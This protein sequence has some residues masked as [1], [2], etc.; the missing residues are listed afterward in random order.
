MCSCCLSLCCWFL[1]LEAFLEALERRAG[2][3]FDTFMVIC[4]GK[5]CLSVVGPMSSFAFSPVGVHSQAL[6]RVCES[7]S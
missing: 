2:F 4:L 5:R 7:I 3:D 1:A 6:C